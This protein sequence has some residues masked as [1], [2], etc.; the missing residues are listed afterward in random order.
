MNPYPHLCKLIVMTQ[1]Q[2][3][4]DRSALIFFDK[5]IIKKHVKLG[6]IGLGSINLLVLRMLLSMLEG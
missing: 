6:M 1:Y 3:V 2:D 4:R 5:A